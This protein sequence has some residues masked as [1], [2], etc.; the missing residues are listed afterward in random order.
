MSRDLFDDDPD[1]L[2]DTDAASDHDDDDGP[3]WCKVTEKRAD[4]KPTG[5][6]YP[7]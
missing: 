2:P 6:G 7:D 3:A 4:G 1:P 5:T